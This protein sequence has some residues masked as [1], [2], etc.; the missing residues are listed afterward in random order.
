MTALSS[1][2][3]KEVIEISRLFDDDGTANEVM[4]ALAG[5]GRPMAVAPGGRG[6]DLA[7]ALDIP[8]DP[9]GW[10]QMVMRG[11]TRW[12]DLGAA[13]PRR[14][15][16]VAALGFDAAVSARAARGMAGLRGMAAYVA[17]AVFTLARFRPP[18]VDVRGAD[19]SYQGRILLVATGNTGMYGG[20]MRIAPG[21][22][23]DDGLFR[24][25][26]IRE[27][28]RLTVLRLIPMV[29]RG[30]HVRHP[31]VQLVD[32]PFLE[33]RTDPPCDIY[34]EGEPIGRTPMRLDVIPKAL[35]IIVPEGV[36]APSSP[37]SR[38]AMHE[39]QVSGSKSQVVSR[40]G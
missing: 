23:P 19:W 32:T 25:C 20:G 11:Q 24:V 40:Q 6:N 34:A 2:A 38:A 5:T 30:T 14:F 16:T 1:E 29:I 15:A 22:R 12:L 27:V 31:R 21:A 28:S 3:L 13:G 17:A 39:S 36:A 7:R 8:T 37:D 18:M 35:R 10:A 26:L 4:Q 33:I 9:G